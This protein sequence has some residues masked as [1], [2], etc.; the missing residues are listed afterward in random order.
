MTLSTCLSVTFLPLFL[1]SIVERGRNVSPGNFIS[2]ATKTYLRAFLSS[3]ATSST[4]VAAPSRERCPSLVARKSASWSAAG[5]SYVALARDR[6]QTLFPPMMASAAASICSRVS[7]F[8]PS[9][10][11]S[12]MDVGFP[13]SSLATSV[14]SSIC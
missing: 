11:A 4:F 12:L 7:A 13:W 10:A 8:V 3:H 14:T 6:I 1:I 2:G 5:T 9:G